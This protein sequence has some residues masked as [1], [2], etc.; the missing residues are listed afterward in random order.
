MIVDVDF[1]ALLVYVDD[2]IIGS[3]FMKATNEVKDYL[4]SKFKLK[5]LRM[6]KYLLGLEFAITEKGIS[7]CQ[8]K[9]ALDIL[10]EH[11]LLR[12]KPISTSID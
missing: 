11:E 1:I 6:P 12:S 2:I 4:N 7:I 8:R 5:D 3:F 9:Y 10:E